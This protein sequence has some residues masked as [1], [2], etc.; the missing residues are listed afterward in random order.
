M[1]TSWPG[2]PNPG[3]CGLSLASAAVR[4]A[5]KAGAS[6]AAKRGAAARRERMEGSFSNVP[7]G[8]VLHNHGNDRDRLS[9]L[10]TRIASNDSSRENNGRRSN[11]RRID[12]AAAVRLAADGGNALI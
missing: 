8:Y 6:K 12:R 3:A 4:T 7:S 2:S 9:R 5:R 11:Y 1:P 10:A